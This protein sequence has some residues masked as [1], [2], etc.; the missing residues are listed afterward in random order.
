[1]TRWV[2]D[3]QRALPSLGSVAALVLARNEE[4]SFT[5]S[6]VIL[7]KAFVYFSVMISASGCAYGMANGDDTKQDAAIIHVDA[8]TKDVKTPMEA[9]SVQDAAD[10]P[11]VSQV[12]T[13]DPLPLATGLPACDTCLG[14]SC[15]SEDQACG[16]DPDCMSYINCENNCI[17]LDGGVPDPQCES[18]CAST[19][20]TGSNELS[21]LDTCMST[22]CRNECFGP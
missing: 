13:C 12:Q 8:G 21:N 22:S 5:H 18:T 15:C 20:P 4:R 9:S 3:T 1:M 14:T 17:P 2:H 19:Y 6:E 11:D 7:V 16:N 10:E